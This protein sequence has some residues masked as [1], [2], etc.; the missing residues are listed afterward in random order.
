MKCLTP[1][2]SFNVFMDISHLFVCLPTLELT[3]FEQQVCS[4]RIGYANGLLL[5]TQSTKKWNMVSFN[6]THQAEKQCNFD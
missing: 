6:S 5:R 2:F 3:T 4:T 1:T